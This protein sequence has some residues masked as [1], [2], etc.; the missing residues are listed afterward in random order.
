MANVSFTIDSNTVFIELWN[1]DDLEDWGASMSD[2]KFGF[3]KAELN[4]RHLHVEGSPAA[5]FSEHFYVAPREALVNKI[6]YD[7]LPYTTVDWDL[8]KEIPENLWKL[9]LPAA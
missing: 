2:Y 7:G 5:E 6:G 9:L 3:T 4:K 1:L 8:T